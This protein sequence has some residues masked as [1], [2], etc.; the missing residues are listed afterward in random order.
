MPPLQ[1]GDPYR[2]MSVVPYLEDLHSP[3]S[4]STSLIDEDENAGTETLC[5]P[6]M[7]ASLKLVY[8]KSNLI[9]WRQTLMTSPPN[10]I[11]VFLVPRRKFNVICLFCTTEY[12]HLFNSIIHIFRRR[13]TTWY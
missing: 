13:G 4:G 3:E 8:R 1:D 9:D 6:G 11:R 12:G 7:K 2:S 5:V 10:H